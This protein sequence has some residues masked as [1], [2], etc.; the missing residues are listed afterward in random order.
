[1]TAPVDSLICNWHRALAQGSDAPVIVQSARVLRIG[2]VMRL[3]TREEWIAAMRERGVRTVP[4]RRAV[5]F[6]EVVMD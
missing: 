4:D 5:C 2:E 1:M 3:A 6:A